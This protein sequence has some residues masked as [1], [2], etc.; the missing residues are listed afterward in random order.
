MKTQK[1]TNQAVIDAIVESIMAVSGVNDP[2]IDRCCPSCR[3]DLMLAIPFLSSVGVPKHEIAMIMNASMTAINDEINH[4]VALRQADPRTLRRKVNLIMN[5][6]KEQTG[7][8]I[9]APVVL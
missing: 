6:I 1:K 4:L 8:A 9:P 2:L 5:R 7:V 3:H